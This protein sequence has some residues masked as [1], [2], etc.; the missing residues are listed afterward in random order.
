M[1]GI[2]ILVSDAPP[3][4]MGR[5][6]LAGEVIDAEPVMPRSLRTLAGWVLSYVTAGTGSYRHADGRVE[7]IGPGALT[8]VP[9]GVPHTYGTRRGQR[10]TELFAVFGGPLFDALGGVGVLVG[11][12]PRVLST[13]PR[14]ATLRA[15]LSAV[16]RSRALAEHQLMALSDWLVDTTEPPAPAGADA[17][18]T[19][20]CE[21]LTADLAAPVPLPAVAAAVGLPYDTFRRRFT[22]E[23]GQPPLAYRNAHRLRSAATLL[24]MTEMTIREIAGQLGYA[25]EFHLSRRFRAH[26]GV[27]P[28]TYRTTAGSPPAAAGASRR[29]DARR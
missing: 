4:R 12:G 8:I 10:W 9:P 3:T 23:V 22:A 15:V 26:F 17:A 1:A 24:R 20:A 28:G 27:A 29:G 18:V 2:R 5:L 16:P 21:L 14:A 7:P 6:V 11:T 19:V 13:P 25:D